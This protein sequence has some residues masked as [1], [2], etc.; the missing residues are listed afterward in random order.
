RARYE[1]GPMVAAF[2]RRAFLGVLTIVGTGVVQSLRQVASPADLTGTT[3]GRLLLVKVTLV[4][5]VVTLGAASRRGVPRQLVPALALAP[6]PAGPGADRL[7]PGDV[8][9]AR[10]RRWA[11]LE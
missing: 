5:G 11:G 10:L 9:R 7:D 6:R 2:S 4:A 1:P 8:P 3:Y